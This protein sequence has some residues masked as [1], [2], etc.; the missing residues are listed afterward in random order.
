M[1][2]Y[3]D[4]LDF[5]GMSFDA[6]IR[7]FLQGFRLPGE[8]QKIDRM[9]EKFAERFCIN[10][11]DVRVSPHFCAHFVTVL[12]GFSC[13]NYVCRV[14]ECHF[15]GS[16][17]TVSKFVPH[18]ACAAI[19][20]PQVFPNADTGFVLAYSV[21]MLNTDAHNPNIKPERRMTR[22]GFVNNNRGIAAGQDLPRE[23]LVGIYDSIV[24]RP[25]TLKEDDKRRE[26]QQV[27]VRACVP[28][29]SQN[30]YT[31]AKPIVRTCVRGNAV[32]R[33]AVVTVTPPAARPRGAVCTD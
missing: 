19:R 4:Q 3:V 33:C 16:D 21:I 15:Y 29:K 6:A 18:G 22:D 1:H 20:C 13:W 24:S 14:A 26:K 10:N 8:A 17:T 11:P 25:I 28:T 31:H 2:A 23:L 32:R 27:C 9:M 30:L 5:T 12:T 7:H